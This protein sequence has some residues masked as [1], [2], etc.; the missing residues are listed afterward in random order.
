MQID[1]PN[2]KLQPHHCFQTWTFIFVVFMASEMSPCRREQESDA[3]DVSADGGRGPHGVPTVAQSKVRRAVPRKP[4]VGAAAGG[5][6]G[7]QRRWT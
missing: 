2:A 3:A 5:L 7:G 6:S 4:G 1:D